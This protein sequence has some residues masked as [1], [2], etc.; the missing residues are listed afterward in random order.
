V[1]RT[2][3]GEGVVATGETVASWHYLGVSASN[4]TPEVFGTCREC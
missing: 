4:R 1:V 3:S 2:R